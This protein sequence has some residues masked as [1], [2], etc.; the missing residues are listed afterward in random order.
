MKIYNY[1]NPFQVGWGGCKKSIPLPSPSPPPPATSTN[2]KTEKTYT[3][4]LADHLTNKPKTNGAVQESIVS[5]TRQR[6][7]FS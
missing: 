2:Y 5:V 7:G 6:V 3:L 4:G 1:Y